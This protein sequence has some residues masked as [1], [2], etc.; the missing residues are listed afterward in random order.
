MGRSCFVFLLLLF[1]ISPAASADDFYI[2]RGGEQ[3][4]EAA[5]ALGVDAELFCAANDLDA[6]EFLSEGR[7]LILPRPLSVTVTV[8]EG[9]TLYSLAR[10]HGVT[11]ADIL[12]ANAVDPR[13][14]PVGAELVI[15]LDGAEAVPAMADGMIRLNWPLD[16]V[17]T[18]PFGERDLGYH[19]GLDIAAEEGTRIYAAAEGIITEADWKNDAYGYAVMID[20]GSGISTLYGHCSRLLVEE[21]SRVM[22]GD[23]VALVGNTGNSTGPHVHFEV[24]REN[25]CSDPMLYLP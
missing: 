8:K 25:C 9:T 15:P 21:G 12:A 17:I 7:L 13:A 11:V 20:H 16:G 2:S 14:L 22:A 23:A 4:A 5:E 1:C 24:R 19:Y 10:A 3:A 6:G 18:S